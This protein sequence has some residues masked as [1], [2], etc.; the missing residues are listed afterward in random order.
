M[1]DVISIIFKMNDLLGIIA[2][3]IVGAAGIWFS[4]WLYSRKKRP[5]EVLFLAIDCINVYN[6]F[7]L[8]F[9]SL[10]I[11]AKGKR[12]DNN[13]LFLSGVFVCNGHADIK[14][15]N[16]KIHIELPDN[17]K[18]NDIKISSKS[19][20]LLASVAINQNKPKQAKLT[21]GQFRMKEFITVKGLIECNDYETQSS[22]DN[23][24]NSIK[25]FHRIEDTEDVNIGVAIRRQMK[26]WMHIMRQIP[27]V[28][29]IVTSVFLMCSSYGISP[30][31]YQDKD[32]K[33]IYS[34]QVNNRGNITLRDNTSFSDF[35]EDSKVE[36]SPKEFKK[37]YEVVTKYEKYSIANMVTLVITGSTVLITIVFLFLRNKH[38]FRARRLL[39]M[40]VGE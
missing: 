17:C 15:K 9:D 6:K 12:I 18:W 11:L 38:Y 29:M 31:T 19:R 36:I 27:F 40:Y 23:F 5:C 16:N 2:T 22:L 21:I 3:L 33:I 8:D 28:V 14:G 25:F 35:W 20:D 4:Y 37:R 32:T 1:C 24:H 39:R 34:A 26:L 13:L 30:L 7:S 10:E